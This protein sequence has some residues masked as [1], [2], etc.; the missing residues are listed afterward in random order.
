MARYEYA[1]DEKGPQAFEASLPVDRADANALGVEGATQADM[2]E[3]VSRTRNKLPGLRPRGTDRFGHGSSRN[4]DEEWYQVTSCIYPGTSGLRS[5]SLKLHQG[6][7]F[8]PGQLCGLWA[9][10][11]MV[12]LIH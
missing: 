3:I 7:V 9:G 10:K 11:F 5:S 8:V 12:S 1:Q 4:H 6:R 2:I